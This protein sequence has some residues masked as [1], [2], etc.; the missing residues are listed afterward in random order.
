MNAHRHRHWAILFVLALVATLAVSALP[1]MADHGG[2]PSPELNVVGQLD[3]ADMGVLFDTE[4]ITDVWAMESSSGGD[5]AYLGTFD[6]LACTFD[7]TGTH[8]VD[9]T[10]PTNP[11]KVAFIA[12]KANTRT[13]DVKVAHLETKS[14]EG[15]ILVA[16]N[17]ACGSQFVPR[18]T[19]N[20]VSGNPGRGGISIWDVTDPTMPHALRQNFLPKNGIH[21]TYIWQ[22]GDSAYLIAVDDVALDDVIIVDITRPQ[23]PKVIARTGAPDWPTLDYSEIDNA[24][25]F[26]HDVWVQE[27]GGQTIAYLSYWD[28][29]LVLLDVSDPGN[30]VFLGDSTY[31]AP[32][33]LSGEAPEGNSH[34][35]VP[36]ADGTRVLMGDEDFAAGGLTS[37][38]I[39]AAPPTFGAIEGA[40]TTPTFSLPGGTYN[41]TAVLQGGSTGCNGDPALSGGGAGKVAII[42]R[43]VCRFDEKASNAIAASFDAM[44][45]YNDAARGDALVPMGGDPRPITGWFVGHSDGAAIADGDAVSATGLFDGYGYLRLLDVTDPG[46]IVELDQFATEGV[47]ENPPLA[48]DF[49]MHNVVV[50]DGSTAY[51]SWYTDGMRVVDFSGDTLTETAHYVDPAGSNFW[52]VYLYDHSDGNTYILGSDRKTGLWIFETP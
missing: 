15:E 44:V 50:D 17:E 34:V 33:P 32:D 41:G 21:N 39:N 4:N 47:F 42:Q 29:G 43:G 46:A 38:T 18:L 19:A 30:P 27:N 7:W 23:S 52:G 49:T 9:I 48:G 24:A 12:D 10:D 13:N 22:D 3:A 8:I 6:D 1:A 25:V 26:T 31:T 16:T 2:S 14:F 36:N 28:A 37:F 20:G 51:I 11:E 5:Y 40:F 45:V 35:A